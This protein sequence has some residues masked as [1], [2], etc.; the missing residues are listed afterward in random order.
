[1]KNYYNL[2]KQIIPNRVLNIE[3]IQSVQRK[4]K[5]IK[6]NLNR[7]REKE[8]KREIINEKNIC[9]NEIPLVIHKISS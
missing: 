8:L 2:D 5:I 6:N 3:N 9:S 4:W 7:E 1:M